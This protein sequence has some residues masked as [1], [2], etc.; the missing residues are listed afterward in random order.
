ME[1]I[2]NVGLGPLRFG[3]RPAEVDALFPEEQAYEDWMGGNLNDSMLYRGI[4]IGFDYCD[5]DGPLSQSQFRE[6]R[7]NRREDAVIWGKNISDWR[8]A[9]VTD[10][11]E[12]VGTR[13]RLSTCGDVSVPDLSLLLSFDDSDRLEYVEMWAPHV[14]PEHIVGSDPRIAAHGS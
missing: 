12:R 13:Y 9:E 14:Q 11:L 3:M 2:P 5:S 6:V 7:V 1:L 8:K 4:I 10:H